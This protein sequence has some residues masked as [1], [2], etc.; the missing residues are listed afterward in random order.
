MGYYLGNGYGAAAFCSQSWFPNSLRELLKPVVFHV[1]HNGRKGYVEDSQLWTEMDKLN[2]G[3]A[4]SGIQFALSKIKRYD[5]PE[6][7]LEGEVFTW[8][9]KSKMRGIKAATYANPRIVV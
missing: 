5:R 6:W 7:Y 1:I 9:M 8:L 2:H 3:F 4:G